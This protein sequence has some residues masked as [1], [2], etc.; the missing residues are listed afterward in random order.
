MRTE[1][2]KAEI[3][4]LW[5]PTQIVESFLSALE[6]K[7][8]IDLYEN[9]GGKTLKNTGP[10]TLNLYFPSNDPV[11][12]GVAERCQA[13]LGSF[14]VVSAMFFHVKQPHVIHNDD[15]FEYPTMDRGITLPLRYVG[16]DQPPSLCL[17]EQW[18][19]DGPS[20][21]FA[22]DSGHQ[23]F[24]NRPVYDYRGVE[25]LVDTIIP[26]QVY[27]RYFTHLKPSWLKGL[28]LD[29]ALPW[30]PGNALIFDATRLHCASDFRTQGI[31]SKLGISIFT[32]KTTYDNHLKR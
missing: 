25:N 32:K 31:T 12:Q 24:Y 20:K 19:L 4:A 18:Y 5:K 10:T 6:I 14:D 28:S 15:S 7:Y 2:A 27:D 16:G 13:L 1:E 22:G 8:L 17:F 30:I 29:A 21:F 23:V 11:L 3:R 9:S 26:S